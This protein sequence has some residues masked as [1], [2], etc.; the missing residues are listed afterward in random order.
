M[1]W[2]DRGYGRGGGGRGGFRSALR[3]VFGDGENVLDWAFP[4]Y[5]AWGIRV[6]IHLIFVVMII[7]ELISSLVRSNIGVAY[8]M[9]GMGSLFLIVLLHEYGHCIACRWV[10]G[11]ADKIL[12]WPLGGLAYCVPPHHWRPSLI[13]TLGGPAVNVLLLPIFGLPLLLL[14]GTEAVL[15]NPFDPGTAMSAVYIGGRQPFWLFALWWLYYVNWLLL[16]FNMLL[17]M[18]PMDGGRVVQELLWRKMGYHRATSIAA[19]TGLVIAVVLFVVASMNQ[20]TTLLAIALFG[21]LTCWVEKQR[22]KQT[23]E[24]P[25]MA[26]YDF[27]RGWRG[28]PGADAEER[29]EKAEEKRR[30][31]EADEQARLDAILAKIAKTGMGSLTRRERSW[32]RTATERKRRG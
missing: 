6:K 31:R 24:D 23:V 22:L 9:L 11:T 30:R 27:D 19:S 16:A 7:A 29:D 10:G 18:Y 12:M 28:M 20:Q 2:E 3:R 8:M 1:G 13:T 21:G 15:F 14:S 5:T 4:L 26:G 17:P 25:A 32:L